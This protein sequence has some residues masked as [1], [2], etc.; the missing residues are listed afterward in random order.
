MAC[1]ILGLVYG[2]RPALVNRPPGKE[3]NFLQFT[4]KAGLFAP[5][6]WINQPDWRGVSPYTQGARRR[7]TTARISEITAM[8]ALLQNTQR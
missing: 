2:N 3:P 7:S 8:T 5:G 1:L 6:I 4:G